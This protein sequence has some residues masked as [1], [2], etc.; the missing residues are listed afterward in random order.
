MNQKPQHNT[1]YCN[2]KR[3]NSAKSSKYHSGRA[4]N[5]SGR[6][7]GRGRREAV[8]ERGA[9]T[10]TGTRGESVLLELEDEFA[11]KDEDE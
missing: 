11:D 5:S 2:T 1:T 9:G 4:A 3:R 10:E 8:S 6:V 7:G